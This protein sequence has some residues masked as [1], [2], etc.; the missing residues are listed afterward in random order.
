MQVPLGVWKDDLFP[1]RPHKP[2]KC[3][4]VCMQIYNNPKYY[5][6][7]FSFRDIPKEVDFIEKVIAKESR[8]PVK[9]FLEIA[10]GNSPHMKEMC[11]RRYR[12]IG[13]ELNKQMIDYANG[14]A[15]D[16]NL[17]AEIFEGDML[18][19]A[20]QEKA[21]CALLFLGSFYVKSDAELSSHL[22]SIANTVRSGGLYIL[23]G[24]ISYFDDDIR[25][26]SWEM[27]DGN[28]KVVTTYNPKIIDKA[29]NISEAKITLDIN[30][31]GKI[32]T[33]EQLEVRKIYSI[34]EFISK[35][36]EDGNW[37][38]VDSFCN[39]DM[40]MKPSEDGR[41]ITVLRRM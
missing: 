19:F 21:E 6:L 41:N 1:P 37:E 2:S 28:T 18:D 36:K 7:A 10:S 35:I 11:K 5:N 23:D 30:E 13:L 40:D 14:I 16:S 9:T 8:I 24:A 22:E 33:M 20:L 17:N 4:T 27:V 32:S 15:K 39:F 31:A 12:Y 3:Y 26:Q 34:E 29:E 25:A 38:Y